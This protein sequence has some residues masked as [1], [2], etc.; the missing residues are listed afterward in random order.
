[1][2]RCD[3]AKTIEAAKH[4]KVLQSF[5]DQYIEGASGCMMEYDDAQALAMSINFK[6]N[7]Q[8]E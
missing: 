3:T 2:A 8:K 5:V 7:E 4:N 1:M 6:L